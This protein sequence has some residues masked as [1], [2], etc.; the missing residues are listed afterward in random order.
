M[1]IVQKQK[2]SKMCV[3]CGL[4]NSFGVQAQFYE[5]E[6][7]IVCG[8]FHFKEEHQSYPGRVHGGLIAAMIDELACRAF[9]IVFPESAAVT[10]TL[11]TKYRK[12][13]PY[14]VPL[15]GVGK[16]VK[17]TH[18]YFEADCYILNQENEVL[19]EGSARYLILPK[20]KVTDADFHEEMCYDLKDQL[21][22]IELGDF[23]AFG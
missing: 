5:L 4:D 3:I 8:L 15:K 13:V 21:Q 17:M 9:W 12:P 18:R 14:S 6:G 2:N 7:K 20:E 1:K 22:E 23:H 11:D 16:I 19:A 10:M